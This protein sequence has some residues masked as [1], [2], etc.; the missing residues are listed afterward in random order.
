MLILDAHRPIN[1]LAVN[2]R[3]LGFRPRMLLSSLGR[4][5]LAF[6]PDDERKSILATLAR[7]P[8]P[9]DRAALRPQAIQRMVANA[10]SQGYA[11]RDPSPASFDSP[12]RLRP[13]PFLCGTRA[14]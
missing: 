2:Y 14:R 5:H 4:C 6:C 1:G 9:L 13:L 10:R 3:V 8:D 11:T 7:S 12:E